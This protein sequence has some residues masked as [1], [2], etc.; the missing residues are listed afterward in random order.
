MAV[1][2]VDYSMKVPKELKEVVDLLDKAVA[3]LK[4]KAP[5]S[6]YADLLGPLMA[7]L[8]GIGG[9][10]EEIKSEYKDEAAAYLVHKLMGTLLAPAEAAPEA[11]A[12]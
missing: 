10:G 9:V 1:T 8:E 12:A 5:F 7:A 3:K 4:A 6:E 2:T 11:P